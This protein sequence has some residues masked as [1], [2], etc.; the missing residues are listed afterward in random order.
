MP[1]IP[2]DPVCYAI[3]SISMGDVIATA[4]VVKWAVENLHP[5]GGEYAV[6]VFPHFQE[7]FEFIPSERMKPY[8][9]AHRYPSNYMIRYLNTLGLPPG[10][11]RISSLRMNLSQFASIK[12]LDRLIPSEDLN[13]LPLREVGITQYPV[14]LDRAVLIVTTHRDEVRHLPKEAVDGMVQW[15][16]ERNYQPVYI[17]KVDASSFWSDSPMKATFDPPKGGLDLR[18]KTSILELATLMKYSRAVVGVDSGPIHL[19]AT[20]DVPIIC[21]YTTVA[22]EHRVPP[23]K[24]GLFFQIQPDIACQYCQSNTNMHDHDYGTCYLGTIECCKQ[25]TAAKFIAALEQALA[26]LTRNAV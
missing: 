24:K 14:E 11:G 12:L 6:S 19:A 8:G 16:L 21:G 25:M 7:L 1:Q 13:Y 2:F 18:N 17:G 9:I 20:T 10:V 15:L 5:N 26:P 4:P 23:R 3:N 22:P